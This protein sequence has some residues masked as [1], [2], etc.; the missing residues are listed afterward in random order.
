MDFT[1]SIDHKVDLKENEKMDKC[2]GFSRE[3]D[4]LWNKMTHM[5]VDIEILGTVLEEP[6]QI[7]IY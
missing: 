1:V 4:K 2:L 6:R 3:L 7:M 5:S